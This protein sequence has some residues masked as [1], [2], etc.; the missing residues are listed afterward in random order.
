MG[1]DTKLSKYGYPDMGNNIYSDQLPYKDWVML[2]NAQRCHDNFVGHMPVFF[3]CMFVNALSFPAF[4][5]WTGAIYM[6]L[7]INYTR[8]YFSVRGHNKAVG[9]EEMLKVMLIFMIAAG[10]VSSLKICGAG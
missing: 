6:F 2:N 4:T 10:M 5:F 7:R 8:A 1:E 3:T 9:L